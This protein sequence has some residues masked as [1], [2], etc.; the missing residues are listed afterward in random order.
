MHSVFTGRIGNATFNFEISSLRGERLYIKN[1]S[2]GIR[3]ID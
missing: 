2:H 3:G 1:F